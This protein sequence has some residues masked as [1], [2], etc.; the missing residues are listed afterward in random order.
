MQINLDSNKRF[1]LYTPISFSN[2]VFSI[3]AVDNGAD[4]LS[5]IEPVVYRVSPIGLNSLYV[6][7]TSCQNLGT[8]DGWGYF[9]IIGS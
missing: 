3:S 6:L 5:V 1:T 2:G 7:G 9:I 8:S 4:V